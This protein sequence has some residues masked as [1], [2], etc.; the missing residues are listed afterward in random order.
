[1][2]RCVTCRNIQLWH[3]IPF[4]RHVM[5]WKSTCK[6]RLLLV[7]G[8]VKN[9][10]YNQSVGY[11][12]L[13]FEE[14]RYNTQQAEVK[15]SVKDYHCSQSVIFIFDYLSTSLSF[16]VN[17][18]SLP[19]LFRHI[20]Q[21]INIWTMHRFSAFSNAELGCW[22]TGGASSWAKQDQHSQILKHEP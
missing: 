21:P 2:G 20:C 9:M 4:M 16:A 14:Q 11:Y 22:M 15:P 1:M 8:S 3:T 17:C 19:S 6:K 10:W 5:H 12:P 7:E 13:W 18:L